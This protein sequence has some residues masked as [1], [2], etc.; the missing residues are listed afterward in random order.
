MEDPP[1]AYHGGREGRGEVEA[2]L[3]RLPVPDEDVHGCRHSLQRTVRPLGE[4]VGGFRRPLNQQEQVVVAI[5][6]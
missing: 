3:E 1:L 5:L 2:G 4:A 6:S